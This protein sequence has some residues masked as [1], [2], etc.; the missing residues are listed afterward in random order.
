M[1]DHGTTNPPPQTNPDSSAEGVRARAER[2]DKI[3]QEAVADGDSTSVVLE[4]L[5]GAGAT[6]REA[7]DLGKQFLLLFEARHGRRSNAGGRGR[8]VERESTPPGLTEEEAAEF[9]RDREAQLHE[10]AKLAR[11]TAAKS[12]I[13]GGGSSLEELLKMLEGP[14]PSGSR[15][16]PA[17]ILEG[18]P[19]LRDLES[20]ALKDPHLDET[21]RL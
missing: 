6:A 14:G 15:S 9:R 12:N 8:E 18:A 4:H 2:F 7:E 16:I 19:H 20:N 1:T 21:W 3:V 5:K 11:I 10:Q 13:Q 17:S